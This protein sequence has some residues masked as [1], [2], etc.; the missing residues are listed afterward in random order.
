MNN[1]R[2]RIAQEEDADSLAS[3]MK[4]AYLSYEEQLIGERLPPLDSDYLKEIQQFPTW[5]M[6]CKGEII[7]GLIMSFDAACASL[8]N[9]ALHPDYQ[10]HG[11]GRDLLEFAIEKAREKNFKAIRLAT[12]KKL[13]QN[14]SMYKH[15]GWRE[16][17]SEGSRVFL[18]KDI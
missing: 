6:E 4:A 11:L 17:G 13:K 9:I 8:S 12:H 16:C 1:C 3:C 7:G 15:L 2:I 5:V 10:G 18:A 14:I